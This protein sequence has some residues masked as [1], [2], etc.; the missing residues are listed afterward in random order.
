M[1]VAF[2]KDLKVLGLKGPFCSWPCDRGR[3]ISLK[4]FVPAS[5]GAFQREAFAA[6]TPLTLEL[7]PKTQFRLPIAKDTVAER[8]RRR[9]ARPMESPHVGSN[10]TGSVTE[11]LR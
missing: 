8:L 9:P 1:S 5:A 11:W 3:Y 10:P 4:H 6:G 2:C 7:A